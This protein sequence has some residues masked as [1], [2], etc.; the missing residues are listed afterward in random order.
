MILRQIVGIMV[1]EGSLVTASSIWHTLATMITKV[2]FVTP[3]MYIGF[4]VT[5]ISV[6]LL[7][8]KGENKAIHDYLGKT[9]VIIC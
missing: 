7:V 2:N 1:V 8:F 3:L 6:I 5:G 9:K 4:V